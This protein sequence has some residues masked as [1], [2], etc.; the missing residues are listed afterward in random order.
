MLIS[1]WAIL[2]IDIFFYLIG[3]DFSNQQNI[4]RF[5]LGRSE[6]VENDTL[7]AYIG[8]FWFWRQFSGEKREKSYAGFSISVL[9]RKSC[10]FVSKIWQMMI[11][12]S[13]DIDQQD[14]DLDSDSDWQGLH[15]RALSFAIDWCWLLVDRFV[16]ETARTA[17]TLST[18][19]LT[20]RC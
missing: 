7:L 2:F 20:W 6:L 19:F 9:V 13:Q 10:Q 4:I 3:Y 5:V 18:V 14:V 12:S 11:L 16:P 8:Q 15:S 17:F 1:P